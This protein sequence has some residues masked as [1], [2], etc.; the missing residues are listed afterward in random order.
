MRI[1]ILYNCYW[2]NGMSGGDRRIIEI[3]R[4]W[5]ADSEL[6][7]FIYTTK[8][9]STLLHEEIGVWKNTDEIIT[10]S[11][12]GKE[13]NIVL[14]YHARMRKCFYELKE[15][16]RDGDI[17][18]SPTDIMPDVIPAAKIKKIYGNRV[19]WASIT[20][21]IFESFYKRPG[22]KINNFLSCMQQKYDLHMMKKY[23]NVSLTTSP[24][25]KQYFETHGWKDEKIKIVDNAVDTSIIDKTLDNCDINYDACFLARLNYSKGVLE[26]PE[27]WEKVV[28]KKPDARLAII[29]K[30]SDE[31]VA[32]I[33]T[34][35]ERYNIEKNIDLLGYM[36][37]EDA[38]CLMKS[39]K[40][41]LFTSHEEGWGMA[42]AEAMCC[43]IPVVAYDLPV[44][45]YLFKKGIIMC[46]LKNTTQ[47]AEHVCELL[48]NDFERQRM[49]KEGNCF[50]RE[51]YTLDKTAEKEKRVLKSL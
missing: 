51:N 17:I 48:E 42:I 49:G 6:L 23:A 37:S 31:I 16:M 12:N 4:R 30:G 26:L 19:K 7:I 2:G 46:E 32:R 24:I 11:D 41:F 34:E 47:M 20:Y 39:A 43:E 36:S 3:L 8:E 21:H 1:H 28:K 9:F 33:K 44:F 25:V 13:K 40:V 50:V 45:K 15:N 5:N 10:N 22:N 38:Y 35:I 29:G 18:Y 14:S 27:I